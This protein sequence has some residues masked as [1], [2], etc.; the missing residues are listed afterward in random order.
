MNLAHMG[1]ALNLFK[2][3]KYKKAVIFIEEAIQ[4]LQKRKIESGCEDIDSVEQADVEPW[5]RGKSTT[6]TAEI[7]DCKHM[8][9]MCLRKL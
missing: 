3:G 1:A 6:C 5:D 8:L 9:A 2:L 7:N 4:V